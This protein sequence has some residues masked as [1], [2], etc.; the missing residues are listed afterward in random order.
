MDLLHSFVG[1]VGQYNITNTKCLETSGRKFANMR[2]SV[3]K[4]DKTTSLLDSWNEII[5]ELNST[6]HN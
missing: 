5:N 3:A 1:I 2:T 6:K 4:Q